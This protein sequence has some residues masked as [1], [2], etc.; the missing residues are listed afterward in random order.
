MC[1][2]A[3]L[4]VVRVCPSFLP[5]TSVR[6][7]FCD[8]I[9]RAACFPPLSECAPPAQLPQSFVNCEK[10]EVLKQS[11]AEMIASYCDRL[12]KR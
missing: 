6:G 4:P 11:N 1:E 2:I 10:A 3:R 9:R 12:L 7:G 5:S 8:A